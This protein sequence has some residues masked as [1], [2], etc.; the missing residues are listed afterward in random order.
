MLHLA[1]LIDLEVALSFTPL[2]NLLVQPKA[3][4]EFTIMILLLS[5][6]GGP[7]TS[8]KSWKLRVEIQRLCTVCIVAYPAMPTC[9]CGFLAPAGCVKYGC[10]QRGDGA[11]VIH[12]L[13]PRGTLLDWVFMNDGLN[14]V[15]PFI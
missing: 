6:F 9:E 11:T 14:S 13:L 12:T 2:Q 5:A 7:F 8:T 10:L 3:T 4:H 1:V 15:F